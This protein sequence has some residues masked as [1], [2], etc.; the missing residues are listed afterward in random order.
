VNAIERH[1]DRVGPWLDELFEIAAPEREAWLR[2]R[3]DEPALRAEVLALLV[4]ETAGAHALDEIRRWLGAAPLEGQQVGPY[5]LVRHLGDGGMGSVHLAERE[6]AE[7]TQRVALKLLR[8]GAVSPSQI[9]LFRR[10][11]QIHAAL[12][13]P[14]IARV[15]DSGIT[16]GGVPY[17]AL[18]YVDGAPIDRHCDERSLGIDARLRL[19]LPVCDAVQ[20]AHQN[21]V[22][23]RD[24]KPSNILVTHDGEPK[25]LDFGIAKL[26][27]DPNAATSPT[28]TGTALLTPAYAA[29]EQFRGGPITTA[30]DV[31]ALG[32]VLVEL[33]TGRR[34]APADTA[35]SSTQRAPS[36]LAADVAPDVAA[37]RGLDPV[38]L[39]RRLKGDLDWIA[40]RA[41]DPDPTRRYPGAG[42]LADDLRRHLEGR[43]IRAR[44][45]S[46]AYRTGKFVRR[47]AAAVGVAALAA[48]SLIGATAF[49]IAQAERARREATRAA[50]EAA[51]AETEA[52][53]ANAAKTFL[54]QLFV[55]GAP[56]SSAPP[57]T[58]A[59][60][61]ERGQAEALRQFEGQPELQVEVLGAI[62]DVERQRGNLAAARAPLER[63]VELARRHF[64]D[65]D[66]RTLDRTLQL[67]EPRRRGGPV[68]RRRAAHRAG[69]DGLPR[70]PHRQQQEHGARARGSRHRTH[71]PGPL[72]RG[73]RR[74]RPG[75]GRGPRHAPVR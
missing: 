62:G 13:H 68:R 29:P 5:R 74:H 71:A 56:G 72:R 75:G 11:Q 20:F 14:H 17:F 46:L 48:V 2:A 39:R 16:A 31:Y 55:Q 21:L 32:V 6:T 9:E 28:A 73:A 7:F 27:A 33:L 45:D 23:H 3:C 30:T 35:T 70:A 41:L 34:P 40:A 1:W 66:R 12:G 15:L 54:L 25:L 44:P 37:R 61:L 8:I 22:V 69:A 51:R 57:D 67:R 4:E 50:S 24:L 53:R 43:P 59:E 42:A 47:N 18:E 64:G 36:R 49:S 60:M 38:A 65:G 26:L 10:E 63:A 19:L 58:A 52:A